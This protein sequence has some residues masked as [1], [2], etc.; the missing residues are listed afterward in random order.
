MEFVFVHKG[1]VE[2]VH[3]QISQAWQLVFVDL[4]ALHSNTLYNI[5]DVHNCAFCCLLARLLQPVFNPTF[6]HH[7]P[8][9]VIIK[10][11]LSQL[12]KLFAV[13]RLVAKFPLYNIFEFGRI[14]DVMSL[15][16]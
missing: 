13:H 7:Q 10:D 11:Q 4:F 6:V 9:P 8:H 14:D 3:K 12:I 15:T 2:A 16:T 5:Q 1:H